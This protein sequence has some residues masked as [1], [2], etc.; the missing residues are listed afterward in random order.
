MPSKRAALTESWPEPLSVAAATAGA[1]RWSSSSALLHAEANHG[2]SFPKQWVWCQGA[3]RGRSVLAV[4]GK[5][6]LGSANGVSGGAYSFC[7]REGRGGEALDGDGM[8]TLDSAIGLP[9]ARTLVVDGVTHYPWTAAPFESESFWMTVPS[10]RRDLL[11]CPPS[12]TFGW[13]GRLVS[14]ATGACGIAAMRWARGYARGGRR[15]GRGGS[16]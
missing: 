11:M 9:G 10:T 15:Q 2:R 14:G 12:C 8:T 13:G 4:G 5:G 1:S 16:R 3:A 7:T 6:T